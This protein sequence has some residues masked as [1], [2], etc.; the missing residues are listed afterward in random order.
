[1]DALPPAPDKRPPAS[2]SSTGA[3]KSDAGTSKSDAATQVDDDGGK[4]T[5]SSAQAEAVAADRPIRGSHRAHADVPTIDDKERPLLGSELRDA[6]SAKL[7]T[8]AVHAVLLANDQAAT[9][10]AQPASASGNQSSEPAIPI[11]GLAVE[12]AARAQAGQ[13][14]F[15]IRLDPP[16]LGRIDVRLDIDRSG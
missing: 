2:S 13:S 7:P 5:V 8:E 14:R 12:I 3:R 1:P 15:E 4:P 16:E 9:A 6:H 11:A 10:A